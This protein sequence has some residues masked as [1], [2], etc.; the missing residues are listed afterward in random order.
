VK[1]LRLKGPAVILPDEVSVKLINAFRTELFNIL[2][3]SAE[4]GKEL[5]VGNATFHYR[6]ELAKALDEIND[7]KLSGYCRTWDAENG[8]P[9][10]WL[11]ADISDGDGLAGS[12]AALPAQCF[13]TVAQTV[14]IT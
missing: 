1:K 12:S 4:H 3:P 5:H 10:N 7:V 8:I 6:N 13:S 14:G 2:Y 11:G 9:G